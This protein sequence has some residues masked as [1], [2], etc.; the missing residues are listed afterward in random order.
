MKALKV[1]ALLL[2]DPGL[3]RRVL[4]AAVESAWSALECASYAKLENGT[5]WMDLGV[6]AADVQADLALLVDLGLAAVHEHH[7]AWV[8]EIATL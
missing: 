3:R 2:H 7:H 8:R 5:E 4:E 1:D 6:D